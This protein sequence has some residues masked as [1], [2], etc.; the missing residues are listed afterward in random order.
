MTELLLLTAIACGTVSP[1]HNMLG[2]Q[3]ASPVEWIQRADGTC[4]PKAM[5]SE[6]AQRERDRML[7]QHRRDMEKEKGKRNDP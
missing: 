5:F 3:H 7:E 6:D 1:A 2:H 4:V